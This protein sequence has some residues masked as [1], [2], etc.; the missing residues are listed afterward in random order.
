[1]DPHFEI[2]YNSRMLPFPGKAEKE[3]VQSLKERVVNIS[4]PFF[5]MIPL[6][7]PI[8]TLY[9]GS[10]KIYH[11]LDKLG[12]S[13]VAGKKDRVNSCLLQLVGTVTLLALAIFYPF[14]GLV[15]S[16]SIQILSDLNSFKRN[17]LSGKRLESGQAVA[18]IMYSAVHLMSVTS[19]TRELIALSLL[20]KAATEL[21]QASKEYSDERYLEC[22]AN[23]LLAFIRARAAVP[24]LQIAY[25]DLF[26]PNLSQVELQ[27]FLQPKVNGTIPVNTTNPV[28]ARLQKFSQEEYTHFRLMNGESDTFDL[29]AYIAERGLS[30]SIYKL[31]FQSSQY[32]LIA[33][34]LSFKSCNFQEAHLT[35][36]TITNSQFIDSDFRNAYLQSSTISDTSF[37]SSSFLN[38][39]F[40]WTVF[41]NVVWFHCD[42]SGSSFNDAELYNALYVSC[43]LFEACFFD[44]K[45]VDSS[46]QSSD[47]TD[48]LLFDTKDSF[49][50]KDSPHRIT[51]PV[52]GL[53]WHF[54][55]VGPHTVAIHDAVKDNNAIPFK[56]HYDLKGVDNEKLNGEVQFLLSYL[57]FSQPQES[58]PQALLKNPFKG[59]EIAKVIAFTER[60]APHLH[61][62]VIP[63]GNDVHPE[64]YG[65]FPDAMSAT[66]HNFLH[67]M[68]EFGI[69]D[70]AQKLQI[71]T[72]GI[73]RGS[74][75]INVFFGGTL[76]QHVEGH[77]AVV[78]HMAVEGDDSF[79]NLARQILQGDLIAGLSMHHQA[80]VT[81]GRGLRTILQ[82]DN[83]PKLMMSEDRNFVLSQ[84][85]P[86]M[87]IMGAYKKHD[88]YNNN[89]NLF[90]HLIQQ[91]TKKGELVQGND[92]I[93]TASNSIGLRNSR[94]T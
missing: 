91:A 78:H 4:L 52:I 37:F 92:R 31:S 39:K 83:V 2:D 10:R 34:N 42:L 53:P 93:S 50:I 75:I 18:R 73:C 22:V 26:K 30:R 9:D 68:I 57:E 71:P 7:A 76:D 14:Y 82:H 33:N 63:G 48:C 19:G 51:R 90:V 8:V 58:I 15:C 28:E 23:L 49:K 17:A 61:G 55:R 27:E 74:Q 80:S 35:G 64:L 70:Q 88:A 43:Q 79:A 94:D 77:K 66:D 47:L 13:Y 32:K 81:I 29:S 41:N 45:V 5:Q 21:Y 65:A 6:V 24:Q 40:N 36:S 38:T 62:L 72:L 59:V 12:V 69:I 20:S 86:E 85:H 54:E 11:L 46:I 67:S 56:F 1:M 89:R 60:V 25:E 84:I 3:K 16:N 87:Y 44:A